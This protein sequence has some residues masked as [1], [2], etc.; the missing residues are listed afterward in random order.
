[1]LEKLMISPLHWAA[2][3]AAHD[4]LISRETVADVPL[5]GLF[6]CITALD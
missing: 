6:F 1:M 5:T 4:S 3:Q 2:V